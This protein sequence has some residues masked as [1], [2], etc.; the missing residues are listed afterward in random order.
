M[1]KL[2]DN[3][4]TSFEDIRRNYLGICE[5]IEKSGRDVRLMAVTK[6]V[7]PERVNYAVGLGVSLLGENRVQEYL[8]KRESYLPAEVHFI[9]GLQTNKVKYIIDKVS[10]IHSVDSVRLAEEINRRAAQHGIIMDILAEINIG[11]E[12]TKG[13]VSVEGAGEFCAEIAELPN[14]RLRGLMTI[15]PAGCA[16]SVFADMREL[17]GRLKAENEHN[18]E[19]AVFDTLSMG[20]SG[21]YEA[22]IKHGATIVRIG[23]GLFGHRK[24]L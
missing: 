13:G 22:A 6:T 11:G 16:E 19:N 10:M 23:S 7:S 14:I 8:E 17:F 1:E 9:G 15:P 3:T 20:M 18:R 21:D 2:S 4:Q 5:N 24:Y 12:Q